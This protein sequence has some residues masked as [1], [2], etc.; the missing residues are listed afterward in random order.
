M[1]RKC[2]MYDV[3]LFHGRKKVI[4]RPMKQFL[5]LVHIMETFGQIMK[6]STNG[7]IGK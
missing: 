5:K 4:K 7:N 1:G 6:L 2:R 3:N